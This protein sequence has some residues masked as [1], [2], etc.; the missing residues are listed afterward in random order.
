MIP[1]IAICGFLYF[2]GREKILHPQ[3]A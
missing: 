2:V 3:K 1:F